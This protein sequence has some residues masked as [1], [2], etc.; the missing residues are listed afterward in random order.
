MTRFTPDESASALLAPLGER[1]AAAAAR[2]P[3][4]P[5]LAITVGEVE[6]FYSLQGDR[7]VLSE[8]LAGP[9]LHHPAEDNGPLPPL[10]RWRRALGCVLEG[11]ALA[12]LAAEADR[13][14][15][16]QWFWRGAAIDAADR[17]APELGLAGPDLARA[18]E[19]ADPGRWP[20]SGVAVL[21]AW[22]DRGE[23]P[24]VRALAAIA[25]RLPDPDEW[26]ALGHH[27]LSAETGPARTL[28]VPLGRAP[29]AAAS[30]AS[31]L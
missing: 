17:A 6:G 18:V 30:V 14:P 20:R 28:P 5:P 24:R 1:L 15:G 2:L 22:A 26:L 7:L 4:G 9:A 23:D 19:R 12:G 21:R 10:D 29:E 31:A 16:E 3:P 11:L 27:I 13:P 8:A 25:G